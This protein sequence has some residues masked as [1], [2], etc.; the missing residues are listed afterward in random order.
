[1]LFVSVIQINIRLL[2]KKK[3]IVTGHCGYTGTKLIKQLLENNYEIYGIDTMWYH[4]TK[5]SNSNFFSYKHDIRDINNFKFPK[6]IYCVIHLANI[7][8]DP[9]VELDEKLSWEVNVLAGYQL[10]QKCIENKVQKF[11]F[12]SSGS[13]YGLKEEEKVTEELSLVPL[14]AYNKTKMIAERVFLSFKDKIKVFN[15]RPATVCG[16]SER[17]RLDVSVNMLT[18][19]AIKKN[20]INVFGGQQVRPNIHIDDLIEVYL[21]FLKN[22]LPEGNYNAGFENLKIIEIAEMISNKTNAKLNITPN[23]NDLRSYRLSSEKLLSTGFKPKKTVELAINELINLYNDK[24][25]IFDET[26]YN[27]NWLTK[28][29]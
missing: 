11:I 8:N 7:A 21:H 18:Y 26:N 10:I 5:I 23:S 25:K 29:I 14:S 19:Q 24:T 15:I 9:S 17:M 27:I 28:K 3:I 16:I 13:V 4:E 6:D 12:A 1:M 2:M 22:D 20:I